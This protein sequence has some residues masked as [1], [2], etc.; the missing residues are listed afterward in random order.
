MSK[1]LK[2]QRSWHTFEVS[3]KAPGAML[4]AKILVGPVPDIIE[5]SLQ[6][7]LNGT[8]VNLGH[9]TPLEAVLEEEQPEMLL[10]PQVQ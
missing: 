10:I 8:E 4:S 3:I 6:V 9:L 5:H 7:V 1:V 2:R